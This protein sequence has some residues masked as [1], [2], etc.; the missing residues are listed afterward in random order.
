MKFLQFPFKMISVNPS[1][2]MLSNFEV[3]EALRN[4]KDTKS[5]FGLRNLA[6]ITYEVT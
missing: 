3:M 4:I 6:T 1:C 2:A 5:K